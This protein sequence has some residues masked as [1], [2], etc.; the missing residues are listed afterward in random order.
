M[1]ALFALYRQR[2]YI[3]NIVAFIKEAALRPKKLRDLFHQGWHESYNGWE[4]GED[5][6]H[7]K[8]DEQVGNYPGR[9]LVYRDA[10]YRGNHEK[11][12]ANWR[13]DAA[14]R[15]IDHHQH[16][17]KDRINAKAK[18]DRQQNWCENDNGSRGVDQRAYEEQEEIDQ[19]QEYERARG[20]VCKTDV[21]ASRKHGHQLLPN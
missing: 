9:N 12:Q 21:R 15:K 4:P 19:H 16:A 1:D 5:D 3:L 13:G 14:N 17:K 8:E 20:E 18:G 2:P 10:G 7:A 6:Q 11:I